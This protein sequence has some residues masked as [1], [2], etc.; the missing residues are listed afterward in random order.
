MCPISWTLRP[1]RDHPREYGENLAERS[2][3]TYARGSSP[4]IRGEFS[5]SMRTDSTPGIIPANTGRIRLR[6]W[7]TFCGRDHPREYGENVIDKAEPAFMKGSSPRIRGESGETDALCPLVGII[8]ANTGRMFYDNAVLM[9]SWD[10]PR[11][12]GEN[13]GPVPGKDI[14]PGSSPRIR[15]ECAHAVG[16]PP[17]RR[18]IPANTG[19]I[20]R[21]TCGRSPCRDHPREY[22]ENGEYAGFHWGT[23]G[24]SPRIRGE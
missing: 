8:P 3:D 23:D 15:G 4:R 22:G 24:S 18:I 19:R 16:F 14:H 21:Q 5:F 10:H 9:K 6:L 2:F 17:L 12:Y 1:P 7:S 13:E 20:M 11:E